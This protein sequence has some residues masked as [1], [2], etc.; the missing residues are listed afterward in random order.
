[1]RPILLTMLTA[2]F[3]A[4]PA[5]VRADQLADALATLQQVGAKGQGHREAVS[6]LQH[7]S[8]AD[9]ARL[10]EMLAALD[11]AGPVAA[12][13]IRGAIVAVADRTLADGERL[14]AAELEAFALDRTHAP[15]ARRLAFEYLARLDNTAADRLIPGMLEDPSVEFR[16]DAVARLLDEAQELW[17]TGERQRARTIY[18]RALRG[19]IDQDQV[20]LIAERLKELGRPIDLAE[21]FGFVTHWKLV[22][23]F[24]STDKRGFAAVYPPEKEIRLDATYEGKSAEVRWIDHATPH[25]MSIVDLNEA[26]GKANGVAAYALAEFESDVARDIELRA[27]TPNAIKIWLNGKL[28][29]AREAYHTNRGVDQYVGRG[30]L[31]PGVNRILVKICQNEQTESWAQDWEFQLRVCDATGSAVLATNRPPRP[32]APAEDDM[33]TR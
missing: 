18:E 16:R 27:G 25:E 7:A 8:R 30:R 2:G 21:H 11:E 31:K 9:A 29:E 33:A 22:G 12:N 6:A 19:A 26:L 28:L 24:D 10:P 4:A 3:F 20:Q 17:D 32:K 1:M 14:P 23:P 15:R 13:W 5:A